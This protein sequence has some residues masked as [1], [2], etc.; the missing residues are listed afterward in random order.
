MDKTI[1]NFY[2]Q[3]YQLIITLAGGL[4]KNGSIHEWVKR[5]LD[6]SITYFNK[7]NV[8]ILCL[9]GGTYHKPPILNKNGFVIHESSACINYLKKNKIPTDYL[10]KEWS[11]YDTIG[12]AYFA[13]VNHI[14]FIKPKSILIIT[15]E[16]HYERTK[17]LF[18]WIVG[19]YNNKIKLYYHASSDD[20]LNFEDR[21]KRENESIKNIKNNLIPKIN[22][23]EKFHSWFYREHNA[24]S[25]KDF[26][27][28][29][30]SED[31]KKTY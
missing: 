9:G 31:T 10:Y 15:S 27:I 7:N 6:D 20:Q 2:D 23:L 17:I 30:I 22:S 21:I 26:N 16:F 14:Q 4:D 13:L 19:M 25:C 12:N 8:P 18:D 29:I 5:R 28:E 1:F 24:Y 3:D 11:S